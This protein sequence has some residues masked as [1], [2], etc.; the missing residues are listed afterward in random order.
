[1]AHLFQASAAF[2]E[3]QIPTI[4]REQASGWA[5]PESQALQRGPWPLD[6][7]EPFSAETR[8]LAPVMTNFT[9][10]Q[11]T[12]PALA[13]MQYIPLPSSAFQAAAV[14]GRRTRSFALFP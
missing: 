4:L 8:A 14:T 5:T 7:L 13:A 11:L 3:Y 1:M 12:N 9:F 2:P 10:R 6:V